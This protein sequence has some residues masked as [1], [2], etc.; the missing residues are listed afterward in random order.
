MGI[1]ILLADDHQLLREGL[2]LLLEKQP[3]IQVVGEAENGL[4]AIQLAAQLQPDVVIMDIHMPEIDGIQ[5]ARRI[6]QE[7]PGVKVICLSMYSNRSMVEDMLKAGAT[8]YLLKECA[9]QELAQAIRT[10]VRGETYLSPRVAR[11]FLDRYL[12]H[13]GAGTAAALTERE[14]Q[15]LR[16]LAEG[17]STKEIAGQIRMSGKTVDA[18]RRQ[19]M[20]KLNV[21]STAELVKYAIREGITTLDT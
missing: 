9:S 7:M 4:V 12:S 14:A 8:G 18:C 5:G 2:R 20:H 21:Q 19:L 3:D 13:R 17:K 16:M 10:V 1:R 15:V 6:L 11:V